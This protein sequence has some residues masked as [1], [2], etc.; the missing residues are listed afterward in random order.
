[1]IRNTLI[2]SNRIFTIFKNLICANGRVLAFINIDASSSPS[3]EFEAF[4]SLNA[5][6]L[7]NKVSTTAVLPLCSFGLLIEY[8]TRIKPNQAGP[9]SHV[10][11]LSSKQSRSDAS[12]FESFWDISSMIIVKLKSWITFLHPVPPGKFF[13]H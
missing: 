4:L 6:R 11:S 2:T 9:L 5:S 1:M 13:E 12:P 8:K 3:I 10:L 7:F